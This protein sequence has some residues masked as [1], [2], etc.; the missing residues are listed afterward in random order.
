MKCGFII[1]VLEISDSS[2]SELT[3]DEEGSTSVVSSVADRLRQSNQFYFRASSGRIISVHKVLLPLIA[4]VF[5][6]LFTAHMVGG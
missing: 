4:K 2:D 5:R 6:F 3:P 1:L